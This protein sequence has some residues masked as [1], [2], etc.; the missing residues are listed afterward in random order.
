[1]NEPEV[2]S[3]EVIRDHCVAVAAPNPMQM[4]ADAVA[5]G[6][7]V[8]KLSKLMDLQ[9]RWQKEEARK[10]F[11]AAMNRFK[12]HPPE[13]FKNKSVYHNGVF[14]Y[15]HATLDVVSQAITSGL[16]KVGI[17]HRWETVQ[18]DA[19]VI[20]VTCILTHEIGHSE[21]TTLEST[22]DASG[23]KNSIQAVGSTVHYLQRYTLLSAT[24]MA[25]QDQDDDGR[26]GK[27]MPE[28]EVE[29]WHQRIA[30]VQDDKEAGEL[31]KAISKATTIAG[32]VEANNDLRSAMV[33][34]RKA[35]KEAL[36]L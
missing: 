16:S 12:E 24:G 17:S 22:P 34:K 20:S 28:A 6:A 29:Q 35:L 8:D 1:M 30:A 21:K 33:A 26:G 18:K 25:V 5:Q 27:R 13:I 10:A 11:I 15:K 9:E 32:D 4:I 7:D 3:V 23:G 19:G 31:W 14:K 36:P 2:S